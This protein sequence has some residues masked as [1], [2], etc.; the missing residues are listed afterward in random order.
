MIDLFETIAQAT[1]PCN[2]P[3]VI[4][5]FGNYNKSV[6]QRAW[7]DY[8]VKKA[9][10]GYEKWTFSESLHYAHRTIKALRKNGL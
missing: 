6:M 8:K 7:Q 3:V 1:K 5:R 9:H 2:I 4:S 10:K